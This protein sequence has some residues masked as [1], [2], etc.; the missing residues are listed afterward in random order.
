MQ[1]LPTGARRHAVYPLLC[2]AVL[3]QACGQSGDLY[4][5]E[6]AA[7]PQQKAQPVDSGAPQDTPEKKT[8]D[9]ED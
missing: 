3:L 6:P 4:L 1:F 9:S 8:Q 5:P 7:P 2:L